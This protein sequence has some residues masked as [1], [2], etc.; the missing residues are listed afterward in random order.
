MSDIA[1]KEV[2]IDKWLWA[3]RFY[4]TR[5][6]AKEAV[7]SGKIFYDNQRIKP[8]KQV[9]LG[10][11]ISLRQGLDQKT[12]IVL[13]L[14]CQRQSAQ[15]AQALYQETEESIKLRLAAAE[16]RKQTQQHLI[17]P[18]TKPNKKDR[19]LIHQF[20]QEQRE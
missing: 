1:A 18:A 11:E 7:E 14:S 19:R 2:R 6:I 3:A 15:V 8:S 12:I 20:I 9:G 5:A 13:A 10:A 17:A 4:K 16:L